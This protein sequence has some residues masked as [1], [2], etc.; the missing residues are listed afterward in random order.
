MSRAHE[1]LE[2]VGL[3]EQ[4]VPE[5]PRVFGRDAPAGQAGSG[6]R[7]R[8]PLCLLN[9]PTSGLDPEGREE[10]LGTGRGPLPPRRPKLRP[11]DTPSPDTEGLVDQVLI[12]NAG[13]LLAAGPVAQLLSGRTPETV[14]R[15]RG[16]TRASWRRSRG[17]GVEGG[18]KVRSSDSSCPRRYSAVFEA[19]NETR[20]Q[21]R[22]LGA[23]VPDHRGPVL[24]LAEETPGWAAP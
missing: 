1:V 20:T 16:E 6:D 3:K 23:S 9:K 7:P 4:R 10:M 2:F 13:K 11:L 24:S 14:V 15:I 18:P 21:V 17:G 19:A 8:P 12:L 5:D 22:Y